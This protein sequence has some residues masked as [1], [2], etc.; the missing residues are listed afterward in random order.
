MKSGPFM[1]R[2]FVPEGTYDGV[3]LIDRLNWSGLGVMVP[4]ERW[5]QTR[6]RSEF[7][8][9]GVYIL[10][11][12]SREPGRPRVYIGQAESV[13]T[14]LDSHCQ[15]KDFWDW[16]YIFTAKSDMLNRAHIVWLEHALVERAARAR[17]CILEN[18]KAPLQPELTE[19]ELSEMQA[20]LSEILTI[21]A[22]VGVTAFAP[23]GNVAAL[24]P[25]RPPEA[26]ARAA[27][28]VPRD[29]NALD[30]GPGGMDTLVVPAHAE[31][32]ETVFL[33][34]RCWHAVRIAEAMRAQ[35]RYLAVYRTQPVCAVTH[36]AKV[37]RIVPHGQGGK[38]RL[39]FDGDPVA[40]RPIPFADAPAGT[41]Q[42]PRY[43]TLSRLC[44][45]TRLAEAFAGSLARRAAA[46]P[47]R[48]LRLGVG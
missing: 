13:R 40:L 15:T 3:R 5:T 20:F 47:A 17:A 10:T 22:L 24:S 11:G 45:A 30:E 1:L 12:T 6:H 43:T 34:Q 8:R 42:G 16:A 39:E 9:P 23:H 26:S 31:G 33:G 14:R 44:E 48:P 41:L 29:E 32:F 35:I 46:R 4:R 21:L 2:I 27:P 37:K 36:Y 25:A 18:G 28:P 38:F 7:A 19:A